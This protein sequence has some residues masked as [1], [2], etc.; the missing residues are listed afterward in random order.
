MAKV[1]RHMSNIVTGAALVFVFLTAPSIVC[2]QATGTMSGYVKDSS[3]A[4]VPHA[5]VTATQV[6]RATT[7]SAESDDE[8]FYKLPALDPGGYTLIVEKHGFERMVQA[9]LSVSVGQN[10]RVDATL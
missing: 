8:G 6:Q 7:Y 9:G 2:A 3:G 10:L 4:V 5:K 1:K